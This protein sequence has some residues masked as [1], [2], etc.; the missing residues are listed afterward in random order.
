MV[1]RFVSSCCTIGFQIWRC[2]WRCQDQKIASCTIGCAAAN[3]AA[4]QRP[5]ARFS[6]IPVIFEPRLCLTRTD[7]DSTAELA[8]C[9]VNL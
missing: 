3:H 4:V 2:E 5:S 7:T 9:I 6:E 8:S 1:E